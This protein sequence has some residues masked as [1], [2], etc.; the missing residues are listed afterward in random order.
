MQLLGGAQIYLDGKPVDLTSKFVWNGIMLQDVPNAFMAI[1]YTSASYTLSADIS[2]RT[3]TR[4][5]ND[6]K[7][8]GLMVVSPRISPDEHLEVR[9]IYDLQSTYIKRAAGS[10]PKAG[11]KAPWLPPSNYI[12]DWWRAKFGDI[13]NGLEFS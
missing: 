1:G 3:M 13:H 4:L 8:M 11:D 9:E 12:N 6:L 5:I 2:A 7:T 10:L